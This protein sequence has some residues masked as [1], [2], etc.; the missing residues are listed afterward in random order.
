M[1]MLSVKQSNFVKHSYFPLE[2]IEENQGVILRSYPVKDLF[3]GRFSEVKLR[4]RKREEKVEIT[5]AGKKLCSEW[6]CVAVTA[7]SSILPVSI[8]LS[9]FVCSNS[10]IVES[11]FFSGLS[12]NLHKFLHNEVVFSMFP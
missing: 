8:I 3:S 4:E 12:R 6:F 11:L 9:D 10:G 2:H 1:Y 5:P 7:P